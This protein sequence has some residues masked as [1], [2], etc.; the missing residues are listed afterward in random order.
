MRRQIAVL[1]AGACLLLGCGSEPATPAVAASPPSRQLPEASELA[2]MMRTL[3]TDSQAIHRSIQTGEPFDAEAYAAS[4]ETMHTLTPTDAGVLTPEF[5][6]MA[7]EQTAR[8]RQLAGELS[9]DELTGRFN[10]VVGS[11]VRCHKR[12]CPGPIARIEQLRID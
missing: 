2:L 6:S 12:Y 5:R 1:V 7:H 4:L 11:C 10:E 9:Q 8:A 3:W